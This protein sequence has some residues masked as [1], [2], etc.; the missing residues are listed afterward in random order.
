MSN[1]Q[2][3]QL[4]KDLINQLETLANEKQTD[5]NNLIK[6]ILLENEEYKNSSY[7]TTTK[8]S[9]NKNTF[10]TVIP[11]PIKNKFNLS[12]GQVL[13][14]DIGDNQ[15]IITPDITRDDLPET[16]SLEAGEDILKDMLFN[17]NSKYSKVLKDIFTEMESNKDDK[18][19]ID[20]IYLNYNGSNSEEEYKKVITYLLDYP[21]DIT[22]HSILKEVQNKI[23]NLD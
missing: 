19:I 12:K 3:V 21:L 7:L 16:P 9:K 4:D 6:L 1:T 11:A 18:T 8:V 14:W 5:I 23:Y 2:D 15:I 13:F 22:K 17:G 20:N 10:S